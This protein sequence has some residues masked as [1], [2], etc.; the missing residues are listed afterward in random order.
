MVHTFMKKPGVSLVFPW[1]FLW[2]SV[3]AWAAPFEKTFTFNQPDGNEIAIWGKGDEFHAVFETLDGYTIM[4]DQ[5][6]KAYV[7]AD[8]SADANDLWPTDLIVGR[9]DPAGRG[10]NLAKHLR[11]RPESA[12]KKARERFLRWDEAT[13]NSRQWREKKEARRAAKQAA[14]KEGAAAPVAADGDPGT[15]AAEGSVTPAPPGS[16]TVGS[17]VGLC[18]LIDFTDDPATIPQA[19]IIDFCNGD[20][21]TGYGNNGSVKKYFQ[22]NSNGLLTYTNVVTAYIRM[23][24]PKTYYNNTSVDCGDQGN[25]LIRDAIAI[26]KALPNY[27]SEIAPSFANLTTDGSGNVVATNVY[28]AGGNGGVWSYGLWPHSW[29]LYNV[30]AQS[31]V[32]GK[33]VFKYQITNIGSSLELGTFCHENGHMLCGYPDIYDYGYD[34]KG[35]AGM[36]CLMNSGGHGTNPVQICAYLKEASG[37]A[38]LV[39]LTAA[40]SL[41]ASV[42]SSGTDFNKFYRYQKP[43]VATEYYLVENRQKSGRDANLPASGIAIWHIDELG[44]KDNQ[45]MVY[46]TSHANYECTLM[47]ADA[48]WHF[49]SNTNSGDSRDLYYLGNAAPAYQNFFNDDTTV[50]ARWW[51]GTNS[52]IDFGPFSSSATT[53]TFTVTPDAA[54]AMSV[55]P[56][57]TAQAAGPQGGPFAPLETEYTVTNNSS[58]PLNWSVAAS[59]ATNWLTIT[60]ASGT[61]AAK[62]SV[63]VKV[64]VNANADS[65]SAG[66]YSPQLGFSNVT[67][68]STL[69]RTFSLL[70]RPMAGFA[71]DT[72]PSPRYRQSPFAVN[73]RAVDSTGAL[74]KPFTGV[75]S[76]AGVTGAS[77]QTITIGSGT[78]TWNYPLNAASHDARTQTIYL[79]SEI[80]AAQ[81]FTGLALQ[82]SGLPGQTLNNFTIRLQ[83]TTKSKYNNDAQAVWEGTGW[84]TVYQGNAAIG[85]TGW[86]EFPFSAPFSYDGTNNLMVDFSFNNTSSSSAGSVYFSTG[87]NRAIVFASNS[88]D[89]DPLTWS[90]TAPQGAR[91]TNIANIK[92]L[93]PGAVTIS[94]TVT[95]NFVNGV[96]SGVVTVNEATAGM[97]LRATNAALTGDSN[98]FVVEAKTVPSVT[99]WPTAS[100]IAYGQSVGD[101]SLSG[102][103]ASVPG[104]FSF[105]SP[106]VVPQAGT[107]GVP[108]VFTPADTAT[109]GSVEGMVSLVVNKATPT[110]SAW[111]TASAIAYGQALSASTLSG[112]SASVPG[113]FAFVSPSTVPPLGAYAAAVR[114]IPSDSN[115][116]NTVDGSISVSV[117]KA[118]PTVSAWPTASA[119]VYGQAL[120]ASTLS[121]GTAS[122]PGSFA[123]AAPA[124]KP[125][126]GTY[127]AAVT[128]T[129]TDVVNY[130]PVNGTAQ[131][132]VEKATPVVH[133]WPDASS[134]EYGKVIADS[135]LSGGSA[136]VPGVFVFSEGGAGFTGSDSF[137]FKVNDGTVDSAPATVAI[138]VATVGNPSPV[139]QTAQAVA[140]PE[141]ATTGEIAPAAPVPVNFSFESPALGSGAFQYT[142]TGAG[143]TFSESAGI[144]ANNSPWYAVAAP[145]GTQACFLQMTGHS[146][147]QVVNFPSA[148]TYTI[149]FS[150]IGRSGYGSMPTNV[151]VD[152]ND[153]L[154]LTA[155]QIGT[156]AWT[157]FTS[158]AFNVTA[159]D[160]TIAFVNGTLSGDHATVVDA[161]QLVSMNAPPVANAQS[162][163]VERNTPKAITLTG[164]DPDGNTLAYSIV[165]PPASGALSGTPPN[166]T[167]TPP[168]MLDP[169][170]HAVTVRFVPTDTTHY[171]TVDGSVD[172]EVLPGSNVVISE[173]PTASPIIYGQ[174]LSASNLSGG[175]ASVPGSFSFDA[176]STVLNAGTHSAAVIFTPTDTATYNPV[177]GSVTVVVGKATPIITAWPTASDVNH[178]QYLSASSL[179]GGSASTPGAFAFSDAALEFTGQETFTFR[180]N[181]GSVDSAP[182]TVSLTV[183]APAVRAAHITTVRGDG[184]TVVTF[185]ENGTWTVPNGVN[186]V[187]VLVVGGG[188]GAGSQ[189]CGAGAGGFYHT[190]SY[191]VTSGSVI[192]VEVG[193][194]GAAGANMNGYSYSAGG[195]GGTSRFGQLLAYGD[196]TGAG[197]VS[198]F[199]GDQGGHS[200]DGGATVIPGFRGPRG[201]G[202]GGSGK[203]SGAGAG[204]IGA[205]PNA[206]GQPGGIG[207]Q[208]AITGTPTYYAGG[209]GASES[210]GPGGLGGGGKGQSATAEEMAGKNGFGGGAGGGWGGG[211]WKGGAPGGSG[212]VIVA[213]IVTNQPPV[214]NP[215]SVSFE[216]N[217]PKAITLTGSDPDNDPLTFE[218][219]TQPVHGMLSGVAP[220]VIYTP[221]PVPEP[222]VYSVTVTFIPEDTANYHSVDGP[223]NIRVLGG[224][225]PYQEWA[226]HY[227]G[228][229]LTGPQDDNDGDGLNNLLEYAFGLNPTAQSSTVIRHDGAVITALGVPAIAVSRITDEHVFSAV[230]GRRKDYLAAGL[231]YKVHFSADLANWVISE[232]VPEVV[233]T[234]DEVDAV[235]VPYPASITTPGGLEKP[236]FFRVS[237]FM[238]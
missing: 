185:N 114:F 237:V 155:A 63:T 2:F 90:G 23:A 43:G 102:G 131:V 36:F 97:F 81:Q 123:F 93:A 34:S 39:E 179:T 200:T 212:I 220:D 48:L 47:Q 216:S 233:A 208:V 117:V 112:G 1:L 135:S 69:N 154:S 146:I 188:G 232:A 79:Q 92:L 14:A 100:G 41:T 11:I 33:Q 152:G 107:L 209:G 222:G 125:D 57:G 201:D 143:W 62:G 227:P 160:H 37:W 21:Y 89:G 219:V 111:P 51:D 169:G 196:V 30:G 120:S 151:R 137:T 88:A 162:V 210:G 83:H 163:E 49:Q 87:T 98:S 215:Q 234:G 71:W 121:G 16:A 172:L 168:S 140:A 202:G 229:D 147:S 150:A 183:G 9:D 181:D 76:L 38:S 133:V 190:T 217:T 205:G 204:A 94:P 214:A 129:P 56:E 218:I 20:N 132:V 236:K 158:N 53:M 164:S 26:M 197:Y 221:P 44:N 126:V 66:T 156:T 35:G 75:A 171:N 96:W 40:S 95:G 213:Y 238:P 225:T 193:A 198:A 138:T 12:A 105:V 18:L 184:Y 115:N 180:V 10:R 52:L 166:V 72:V 60:P 55:T 109:Y 167:Y 32:T 174:A 189:S 141:M 99:T 170:V 7:Y 3:S 194:G 25:I 31:L 136:S 64:A 74:F 199:G 116:Q 161:I 203:G 68:G 176:P 86:V 42:S 127:D 46:N 230:F 122:V 145:N 17:K 85:Q 50:S 182:A 58:D 118:T 80:G 59:P 101:S 13:Q 119:I 226:G 82:V 224:L 45:S 148:G 153:V 73:V 191:P 207:V 22:D 235:S 19:S 29:S 103:S 113:T 15:T 139:Q 54:Y 173:W 206:G 195:T 130:N 70:V 159:G 84:T 211:T 24:Q 186:S 228:Y 231:D 110:V 165:N 27:A 192:D 124:T 5:G 175:T 108:V 142:P 157:N 149:T 128:F 4:F 77:G 28:Y 187:E 65:L 178:G 6:A 8:L 134:I 91:S 223:V 144:A 61:L 67:G 78:G 177:P 104:N 106:S